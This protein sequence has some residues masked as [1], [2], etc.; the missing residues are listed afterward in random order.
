MDPNY[1]IGSGKLY[2]DQFAAGTKTRSGSERYL[3][4]SPEL[5]LNQ[6]E[7]TVEHYDSDNGKKVKDRDVSISNDLGGSFTLD[8]ISMANM[9]LWFGGAVAQVTQ[10]AGAG[11]AET[12]TGAQLGTYIQL[13]VDADT[14]Q[15][16][17]KISNVAINN[18]AVV[19]EAN[20]YEVD[21]TLG[22]IYILEDAADISAG[23]DLDFT[24]DVAAYTEE[25]VVPAGTVIE[26]RMVF[27]AN[28]AEGEN[29][30]YAWPYV[31]IRPDGDFALK[32]DDWQAMTF[33][34]EVLKL[35]DSTPSS[36]AT[37]RPV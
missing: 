25:Q 28:N 34:F 20:N 21:E 32:G 33:N 23:D 14:P 5:G 15:G 30:D 19:A 10:A 16:V 8:D 26:G 1:V 7:E 18:G 37:S 31:K 9:A 17:R 2:F 22:R 27:I 12:V 11:V 3:G 6:S 29:K 24:Y 13:G 4:N 35:N 36:A